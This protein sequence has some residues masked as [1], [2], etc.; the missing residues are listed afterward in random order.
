M[1][2][3]Q[4]AAETTKRS[5]IVNTIKNIGA[6]AAGA[7]GFRATNSVINRILPLLNSYVPETFAKKAIE[8]IDPRIG[9][10]I[11]GAEREG[12]TFDETKEFIGQKLQ[13]SEEEPAKESRN[14]IEQESPELHSFLDQEI[15]K[16]RKPVEAGA[17]AQ[18]DKRFS[19]IIKKLM[20]AH[21]TPWSSIVESIFG[22]GESALPSQQQSNSTGL[23]GIGGMA[24]GMMSNFYDQAF[25]ALKQGSGVMAGVKDP[26]LQAA[27]P[28]FDSGQIK[29]PQDLAK[30]AQTL[31]GG[32]QAQEGQQQ[33]GQGLDAGV[34]QILQQGN[35]LLKRFRGQ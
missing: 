23:A 4:E 24:T 35:E 25:N 27:K 5:G 16:G 33:P 17:L 30:F 29:S 10:F 12:A 26:L 9:E 13:K 14:I 2:P 18:N 28:A 31:K 1:Q 22:A 34:A 19:N 32:Q 20:K 6:G 15:R 11:E 7:V 21:K 8:K 3:Y